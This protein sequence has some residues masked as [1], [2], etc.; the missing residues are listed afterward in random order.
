MAEFLVVAPLVLDDVTTPGGAVRGELG[1]SATYAALAARHFAPTGI[2]AIVGDDFPDAYLA[3]LS[4]IDL[5]RVERVAGRS[6]RWVAEHR[7]DGST[8]TFVN[9][10]GATGGRLPALGDLA[11]AY[12]L[13]GALEPVLQEAVGPAMLVAVDTMPCYID[14]DPARLRRAFAGADVAFLTVD[15]AERLARTRRASELRERIGSRILVLKAGW[16]GASVATA[17]GRLVIPAYATRAVD[18]TG[19]GDAFA[20]AFIATLAERGAEDRATLWLAG[21]RG[22]AAASIAVEGFGPRALERATRE[23]IERRAAE[24]EGAEALA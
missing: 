7:A 4:G 20:G 19:A 13:V 17:D 15:E 10:P 9:D 12:V 6:F 5:A 11:G 16:R 23:E 3:R 18:P 14:D 8:E 21:R 24:L 2:A 1:G 22:A